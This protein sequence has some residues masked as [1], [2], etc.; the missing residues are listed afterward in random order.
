MVPSSK[1][2]SARPREEKCS[3]VDVHDNSA[4]RIKSLP[5]G[6]QPL[7]DRDV[8]RTDVGYYGSFVAS[9]DKSFL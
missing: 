3:D 8:E 5:N 6:V 4:T 9:A 7:V 2:C 1:A